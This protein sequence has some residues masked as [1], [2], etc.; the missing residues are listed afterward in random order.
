[1]SSEFSAEEHSLRE[2]SEQSERVLGDLEIDLQ[3]TNAKL[4]MLAQKNAQYDVL[5]K[6]CHSLEELDVLGAS[7]LFWGA[8][9]G[10][11]DAAGR[12]RNARQ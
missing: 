7:H 10:P 4:D 6:V 3:A 1:M 12:L 5:S 11:D 8:Q 2:Q 9:S